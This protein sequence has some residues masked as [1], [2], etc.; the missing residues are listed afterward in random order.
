MITMMMAVSQNGV[1]GCDTGMPWHVSSELKFFKA[2]T[3]GKRIVMGRKTAE[4]VG[5]LPGRECIVVSRNRGFVVEGF[6]V[7]TAYEVIKQDEAILDMDTV[8][9]GGGEIYD[10]FMPYVDE[11][12]VSRLA[13][14]AEGNV[15]MP[16]IDLSVWKIGGYE[17]HPEF[18]V[19][20]YVRVD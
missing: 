8:I 5:C 14:T 20:K 15:L 13:V 17:N 12:L 19:E 16:G 4:L 6:E 7:R 10:L 1:I 2:Q 11:I 3:M 18:T 9:C